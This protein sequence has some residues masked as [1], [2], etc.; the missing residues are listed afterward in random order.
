MSDLN[1]Y[2][3][4]AVISAWEEEAAEFRRNYG[5]GLIRHERDITSSSVSTPSPSSSWAHSPSS[6]HDLQGLEDENPGDQEADSNA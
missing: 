1:G 3:L 6:E 2:D 5:K 4:A